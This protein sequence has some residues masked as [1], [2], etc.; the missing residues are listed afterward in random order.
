MPPKFTA[1]E[2]VYIPASLLPRAG[3]NA[4]FALL[5]RTVRRQADHGRAIWIDDQDGEAVKVS[6][7]K[8]QPGN[9]GFCLIRIGDFAT[10][11]TLLDPLAKSVLQYL[12]L[13]LPDDIVT[14]VAV[15][16]LHELEEWW[17]KHSAAQTH[18][19]LIGHGD[20][21]GIKF[22]DGPDLVS[23]ARLGAALTDKAAP[24][25]NPVAFLSL[26]CLTGRAEF[27]NGFSSSKICKDF[28][29][30]MQSVH[31]AS[32]SQ[33]V[34]TLLAHHLLDGTELLPAHRRANRSTIDGTSFR[35][36]RQGGRLPN[37]PSV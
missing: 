30:P 35:F 11:K 33:Y 15:R 7:R 22:L 13:M 4:P 3:G 25:T 8:V 31:G 5:E 24:K 34:Q 17:S 18:C 36:F 14:S 9:L 12:R 27:G 1:H 23:G 6:T 32:A 16:T 28:I 26:S 20:A 2:K 37:D 10:E 21:S 29:G 19:V